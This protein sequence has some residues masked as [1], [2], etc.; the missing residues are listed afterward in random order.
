MHR[1]LADS[2]ACIEVA[3]Q[4]NLEVYKLSKKCKDQKVAFSILAYLEGKDEVHK[5]RSFP[6]TWTLSSWMMIW[7]LRKNRLPKSNE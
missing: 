3:V 4:A 7:S 2:E 5:N 6:W 1:Q